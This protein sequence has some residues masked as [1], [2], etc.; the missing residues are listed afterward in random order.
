MSD[1]PSQ[2]QDKFIVRLPEGMRKRIKDAAD[3]SGRSM[4]AEIVHTLEKAYPP[5]PSDHATVA[6]VIGGFKAMPRRVQTTILVE[7]LE[8]YQLEHGES[9]D[10]HLESRTPYPGSRDD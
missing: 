2:S 1:A 3:V 7:A 6:R 8:A 4:N 10:K 5:P 9:F